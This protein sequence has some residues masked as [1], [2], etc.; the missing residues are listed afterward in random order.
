MASGLQYTQCTTKKILYTRIIKLINNN[1][2]IKKQKIN[3]CCKIMFYYPTMENH[4]LRF[5]HVT[6]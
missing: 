3:R 5:S 2:K 4:T 1:K 6:K